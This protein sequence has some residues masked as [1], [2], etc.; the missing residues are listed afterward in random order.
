MS[1]TSHQTV[2]KKENLANVDDEMITVSVGELNA[3]CVL[4]YDLQ[5][6]V[7]LVLSCLDVLEGRT[8]D[9][10]TSTPEV[11]QPEILTARIPLCHE[12]ND[13]KGKG[14]AII[15]EQSISSSII[16]LTTTK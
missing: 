9:V 5:K 3:I 2:A 15:V 13:R 10:N 7:N 16:F 11:A 8:L 6:Q 14:N 12:S 1:T 4:L